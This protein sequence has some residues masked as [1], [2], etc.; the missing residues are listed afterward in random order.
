MKLASTKNSFISYL[1][2]F[3]SAGTLICCALP[4]L[5]VS[6]GLGAV[7]AG[8][9]NNVPGLIWISEHKLQVFIFAAVMLS[10]N[11]VW[12][13]LNRNAPCPIDPNLRD[14]CIRGRKFSAR[15]YAVS[16]VIF[17]VGIFFAF[18]APNL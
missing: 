7:L 11:G 17:L 2:L 16:V 13:Y 15:V 4:A 10:L 12:L 9:A 8:L 14:A 6:V 5:L 18:I 1:T 3:S